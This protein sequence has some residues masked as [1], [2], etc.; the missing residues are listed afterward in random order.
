VA[1]TH[2]ADTQPANNDVSPVNSV[3]PHVQP[4]QS[5]SK[6]NPAQMVQDEPLATTSIWPNASTV[7]TAKKHV[8]SKP[9]SKVPITNLPQSTA[10]NYNTIKKNFWQ[11]EIDGNH[12]LHAKYKLYGDGIFDYITINKSNIIYYQPYSS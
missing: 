10:N 5:R 1:N 4:G 6:A 7:A 3:N 9:L 2:S 11:M 12:N 8:Q